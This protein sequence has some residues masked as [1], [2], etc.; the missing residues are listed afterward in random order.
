MYKS[1]T[2]KAIEPQKYLI[3]SAKFCIDTPDIF[4]NILHNQ[5]LKHKPNYALYRDKSNKDYAL[6][7][8]SFMDV[9]RDF[10]TVKS[11]IHQHVDLAKE[12]NATGVHL[13]STQFDRIL[14]AK[15]SDLEVIIST[16]T[17][18]EVLLAQEL[19]ADAVTYSPIFASPDKGEPKGVEEL[20]ELLEI[21]SIP[22]F[23]LGG[24]V[25]TLHVDMIGQ[26]KAYGF[27][28]IRYF[29]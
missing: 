4:K 27:A 20:K 22:V 2:L 25:K 29:K 19:G 17:F 8:S 7:A 21:C 1:K 3:T 14:D 13:T 23:A 28:S 10:K 11:F 5:F 9:C 15:K 18:E 26:T 24:I 12:L 6:G 16:H